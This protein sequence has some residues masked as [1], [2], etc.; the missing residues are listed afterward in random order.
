MKLASDQSWADNANVAR[1]LQKHEA[2]EMELRA[3]ADRV[4]M[5]NSVRMLFC[6]CGK[7]TG[8]CSLEYFR[9]CVFRSEKYSS[10]H[11]PVYIGK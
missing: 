6:L 11:E 8:S 10:E 9:R 3:N 7:Y 5:L 4:D 1:K 2:L